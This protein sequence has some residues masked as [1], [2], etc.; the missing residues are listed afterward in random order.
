MKGRAYAFALLALLVACDGGPPPDELAPRKREVLASIGENVILPVYRNFA[1]AAAAL[2]VATQAYAA[3]PSLANRAAAQAAWIAAMDLWQYAELTQLGPAGP[4]G[5]TGV[6]GGQGLRDEIYSYPTTSTC[7]I[8]Q[9]TVE[10]AF[11]NVDAFASEL[12]EVRGL[13]AME[14]LLFVESTAN[15]CPELAAINTEGTWAALGVDGLTRN[16]AE[17]AH[18]LAVLVSR[19]AALLRDAWEPTGG[20]FV[21]QLRTA[22]DGSALFMTAQRG[23]ND[24]ATALHYL[25]TW[26]KDMKVGEPA[27]IVLCTT[28]TCLESLESRFANRSK[29]NV[30]TNLLAFRR[31]FLGADPGVEAL[32]LDD[33]LVDVG[34]S[35]LVSQINAAMD[36]ALARVDAITGTL[37]EAIESN[38]ML[39]T[40]LYVAISELARLFKAD[41]FAA[42]DISLTSGVPADND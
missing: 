32:G 12:V 14:Y 37:R 18:T 24:L 42:L 11:R 21:A 9:E 30:R 3:D 5:S 34:H 22:G 35:S 8:D 6:L 41:L 23:I 10:G 20:D 25:D 31:I 39:V 17:Y 38:A 13:D 36:T 27:G 26:T 4:G 16:R 40:D 7:R 15:T 28:A 19:S 29:E 1:D 33:L 2:E